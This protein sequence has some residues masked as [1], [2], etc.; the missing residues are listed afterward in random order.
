M[1]TQAQPDFAQPLSNVTQAVNSTAE[2]SAVKNVLRNSAGVTTSPRSNLNIS[3][4]AGM[5]I[6]GVEDATTDT[7]T[8]TFASSLVTVTGII[9]AAGTTATAGTGFSYTHAVTGIYVFT[10]SSSFAATPVVVA[11]PTDTNSG[12]RIIYISSRSSSGFTASIVDNAGT[13]AD[14]EFNFLAYA[15]T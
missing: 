9:P 13:P 15:V 4:G 1:P 10:F 3:V 14:H 11:T 12:G 5:T 7:V 8:L 2:V 6:T